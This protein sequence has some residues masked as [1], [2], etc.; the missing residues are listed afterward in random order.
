MVLLQRL[1]SIAALA[2]CRDS[3]GCRFRTA[4]RRHYRRIGINGRRPDFDLIRP[5]RLPSIAFL[6]KAKYPARESG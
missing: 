3:E 2:Q 1:H 5:R 4:D 6:V